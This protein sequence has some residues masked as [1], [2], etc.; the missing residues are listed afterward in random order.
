MILP[1]ALRRREIA[2][3]QALARDDYWAYLR[4]DWWRERRQRA[5]RRAK[6]R[7]ELTGATDHLEVHHVTYERIGCERD[8]DLIVIYEPVHETIH[9]TGRGQWSRRKLLAD[10]SLRRR[11][12]Q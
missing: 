11:R 10:R 4:T 2:R 1:N 12:T 5:L 6:H 8:S 7:C 3:L 9:N